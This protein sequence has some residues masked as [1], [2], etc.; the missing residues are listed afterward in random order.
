MALD[1]FTLEKLTGRSR[2][3]GGR[4][5]AVLSWSATSAGNVAGIVAVLAGVAVGSVTGGL[6]PG[7]AGFGKT[8][9]GIPALEAWS[10]AVA[11][12]FVAMCVARWLPS[13][14]AQDIMLGLPRPAGPDVPDGPDAGTTIN[15]VE[16]SPL[17]SGLVAAD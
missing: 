5:G 17:P 1:V 11:V 12:Y 15:L 6:V 13:S 4:A 7:T 3:L 8:N 2:G 16:A 9:V 14:R 10:T